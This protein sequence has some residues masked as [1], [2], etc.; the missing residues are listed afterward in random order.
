MAGLLWNLLRK[1][2]RQCQVLILVGHIGPVAR[3]DRGSSL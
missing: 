1:I 2:I 3:L